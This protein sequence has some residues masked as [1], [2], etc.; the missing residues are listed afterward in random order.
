[1]KIIEAEDYRDG[2]IVYR[3][4]YK[5]VIQDRVMNEDG[6]QIEKM[7]GYHKKVNNISSRLANILLENGADIHTIRRFAG[8]E[9]S[10]EADTEE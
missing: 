10:P 7:I 6:T 2:K 1:M 4:L 8:D 5:Y 3:T 9:W